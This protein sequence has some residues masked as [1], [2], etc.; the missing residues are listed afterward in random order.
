MITMNSTINEGL[1]LLSFTVIFEALLGL[2]F[3]NFPLRLTGWI[4]AILLFLFNVGLPRFFKYWDQ[5]GEKLANRLGGGVGQCRREKTCDVGHNDLWE[6]ACV[7]VQGWRPTMEDA[8]LIQLKIQRKGTLNGEGNEPTKDE[9]A[10][11]VEALFKGWSLFV[12]F[13][14]HGGPQVSRWL[15]QSFPDFLLSAAAKVPGKSEGDVFTAEEIQDLLRITCR[16]L[17]Y[18]LKGMG[19]FELVG[20]TCNAVI[21]NDRYLVCANV[22]DSRCVL[23]IGENEHEDVSTDHKPELKSE[24]LRIEKAGGSVLPNGPCYRVDGWG[25]NLSR[26]FGDFHYKRRGDLPAEDQKV[27]AEPEINCIDMSSKKINFII[28]GCDGVFEM[29]SLSVCNTIYRNISK[30]LLPAVKTLAD[31]CISPS[32]I[33]TQG[34][35]G[36]NVSAILLKRSDSTTKTET[37]GVTYH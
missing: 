34:R 10:E 6:Y 4:F 9:D 29:G 36:D 32:L 37:S 5:D 7:E 21:M 17:D 26:A 15:A 8:T 1:K 35:G 12:V 13:D 23:G 3:L 31:S 33:R 18:R 28:I 2:D 22:G 27:C 11:K 25:L 16:E 24:R 14:G 20:S 19:M 30:G